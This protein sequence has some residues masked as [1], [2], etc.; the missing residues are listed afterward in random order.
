MDQLQ[1]GKE[2]DNNYTIRELLNGFTDRNCL[3]HEGVLSPLLC[4]LMM[5]DFLRDSIKVIIML[6]DKQMIMQ[7]L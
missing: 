6:W 1:A 2:E 4:S 3:L 5:E 7:S